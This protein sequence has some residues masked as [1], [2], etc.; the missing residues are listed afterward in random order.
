LSYKQSSKSEQ[1]LQRAEIHGRW[2]SDYLNPDMDRFYDLAFD[3]IL[4]RLRLKSSDRLLDAGCG[5][6]Y[7]TV[8]LARAGVHIT[9]VDFS[10]AALKVARQTLMEAGIEKQIDLRRGDITSLP[11]GNAAFD[12]VICW[13]VLMHVPAME[14]ALSELARVLKPGGTLVL[15]ENNMHSLDVV[16]RENAINGV[17]KLLGRDV[18]DVRRTQ[19]GI[20]VWKQRETGGLMVRKARIDFL[21]ESL[22]DHGLCQIARTAGQFTEAYTNLPGRQFKRIAYALNTFYFKYVR[23][24]QLA[25]GNIIYFRKKRK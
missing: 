2:A 6:C 12:A 7:H 17:K 18:P 24:P 11:F 9:A 15:G 13:G 23:I 10:D 3:A 5:Y 20:E 25:M 22:A 4:R 1:F 19:R 14:K 21:T 8:R 16:L